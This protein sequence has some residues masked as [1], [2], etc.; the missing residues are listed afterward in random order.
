MRG[1]TPKGQIGWRGRRR[2]AAFKA[3][4]DRLHPQQEPADPKALPRW[5]GLVALPSM[6]LFA[7]GCVGTGVAGAAGFVAFLLPVLIF[8][9]CA[10]LKADLFVGTRPYWVVFQKTNRWKPGESATTVWARRKRADPIP[11]SLSYPNDHAGRI[12]SVIDGKKPR[13]G[14]ASGELY[15]AVLVDFTAAEYSLASNRAAKW[16]GSGLVP[17]TVEDRY[18]SASA[19]LRATYSDG[20]LLAVLAGIPSDP[21]VTQEEKERLSTIAEAAS[22]E[23]AK[24]A[25]TLDVHSGTGLYAGKVSPNHNDD[26]QSGAPSGQVITLTTGGLG[27]TGW[28]GGYITNATRSETRAIVSHTDGTVTLEGSLSSWVNGDDLDIYDAWDTLQGAADQLFTDQGATQYGAA[29]EI[30][31]YDGTFTEELDPD[32]TMLP[33]PLFQLRIWAAAGASPVIDGEG[34]RA[35]GIYARSPWLNIDGID[36]TDV[37]GHAIN[38]FAY[39]GSSY[40]SWSVFNCSFTEWGSASG[41]IWY[42]GLVEDCEADGTAGGLYGIIAGV[43]RRCDIHNISGGAV[44]TGIPLYHIPIYTLI[45]SCTIHDIT[46]GVLRGAIAYDTTGAQERTLGVIFTNCTFYNLV[47]CIY[48]RYQLRV[49]LRLQFRNCVFHT[50]PYVIY[51]YFDTPGL[52]QLEYSDYNIF[53]GISTNYWYMYSGR[54]TL[55]NFA[56]WQGAGYDEHSTEEDPKMTAPGSADFSLQTDSPCRHAGAGTSVST[57]ING[58]ALDRFHPDIGA[59]SSGVATPHAYSGAG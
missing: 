30:R 33:G 18:G 23:L 34:T 41:A 10:D 36:V 29:Q 24:I 50:I 12:A 46:G 59:W 2:R 57:G 49:T 27:S 31:A 54:A 47:Y 32:T 7:G 26:T 55:S 11:P 56:A 37:T 17:V 45:E 42:A 6:L 16:D 58:V 43:V 21:D 53:Y 19:T 13:P 22:R 25:P 44:T 14:W 15:D 39:T 20:D 40:A 28:E 8:S 1:L 35:Y 4:W 48:V 38:N 3:E 5:S 51:D 9:L 52:V